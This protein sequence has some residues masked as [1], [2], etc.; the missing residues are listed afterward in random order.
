MKKTLLVLISILLLWLGATAWIGAQVAPEA[1]RYAA[2][3]SERYAPPGY[4][5]EAN[6]TEGGLV[7]STV[8]LALADTAGAAKHPPV[9]ALTAK[10]THGPVWFSGGAG[11]GLARIETE[12]SYR[13]YRDILRQNALKI[14]PEDGA[15]HTIA[16][17]G[18]DGRVHAEGKA[19]AF[20]LKDLREPTQLTVAPIDFSGDWEPYTLIGEYRAHTASVKGLRGPGAPLF[21]IEEL[22]SAAHIDA[23][24]SSWVY[25]GGGSV[26]AARMRLHDEQ[27]HILEMIPRLAFAIAPEANGTVG[28]TY[29]ADLNVT[30]GAQLPIKGLHTEMA[31]HGVSRDGLDTL[32]A[33]IRQW[34]SEQ[35]TLERELAVSVHQ[36]EKLSKAMIAMQ[37]WQKEV[38]RQG[39][40]AM[41]GMLV[42]GQT[43]LQLRWRLETDHAR[44]NDLNATVR[45]LG[46]LP[47]GSDPAVVLERLVK[48]YPRYIE[49]DLSATFG[50]HLLEDLG[51]TGRLYIT[52]V[53]L[54]RSQGYLNCTNGQCSTTIHYRPD[55]LTIN[56]QS[57]PKLLLMIK[58]M[59]FGGF[60]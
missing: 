41:V 14:E 43:A 31:L 3:L 36:P 55:T 26:Q 46:P 20:V 16:R 39:Q 12:Q 57:M 9:P 11:A 33:K 35:V 52:W 15:I 40:A 24:L 32:L 5:F 23:R 8:R 44:H 45:L 13:D 22:Q 21:E 7:R 42:P 59:S 27:G 56:G 6:V 60:F 37:E 58:M 54:A 48:Q 38:T 4:R 18:F 49:L 30:S 19:D 29:R 2:W 50:T 34:Q 1:Q 53:G 51:S 10:V 47:Q 28:V 25:A 17:I